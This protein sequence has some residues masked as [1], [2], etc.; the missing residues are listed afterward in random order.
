MMEKRAHLFA[1]WHS[2]RV[3]PWHYQVGRGRSLKLERREIPRKG[4]CR[5][6][7]MSAERKSLYS[8]PARGRGKKTTTNN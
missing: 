8:R 2:W 3:F 6:G 1:E 5:L 4:R 7:P